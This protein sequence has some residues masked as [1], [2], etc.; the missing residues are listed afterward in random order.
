[1]LFEEEWPCSDFVGDAAF[2]DT[3]LVKVAGF[4]MLFGKGP[5]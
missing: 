5:T 4:L 3:L 2:S 1:M